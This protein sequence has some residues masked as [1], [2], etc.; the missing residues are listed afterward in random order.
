MMFVF[1]QTIVEDK[2]RPVLDNEDGVNARSRI[3]LLFRKGGMERAT[4]VAAQESGFVGRETR[5]DSAVILAGD[6]E[7]G[8]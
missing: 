3:V 2:T 6:A 5:R 4:K 7:G 8:C 1:S